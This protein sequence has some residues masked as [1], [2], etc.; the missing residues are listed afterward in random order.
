MEM[1]TGPCMAAFQRWYYNNGVCEEFIYGGC[2]GNLNNFPTREACEAAC[3]I[4]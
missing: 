2:H 1:E 4:Y 3:I